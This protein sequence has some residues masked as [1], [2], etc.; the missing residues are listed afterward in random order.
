MANK[1]EGILQVQVSDGWGVGGRGSGTRSVVTHETWNNFYREAGEV[2]GAGR[3]NFHLLLALG[4]ELHVLVPLVR[5][6]TEYFLLIHDSIRERI[7][8]TLYNAGLSKC[9]IQS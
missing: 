6:H 5:L 2:A 9:H 1:E 7:V 3:P 4:P 8:F